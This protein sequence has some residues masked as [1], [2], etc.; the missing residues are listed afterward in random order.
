MNHLDNK[1][2]LVSILVLCLSV[3]PVVYIVGSILLQ[4]GFGC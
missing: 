4:T 3:F 2:L 1:A